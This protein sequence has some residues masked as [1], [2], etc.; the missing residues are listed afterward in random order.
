MEK[1]VIEW[2][3][4]HIVSILIVLSIFIQI[5]PIKINPWSTLIKWVGKTLTANLHD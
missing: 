3:G 1:E 4:Q 5:A 2:I